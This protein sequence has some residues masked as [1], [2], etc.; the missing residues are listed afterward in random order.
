MTLV[1][2]FNSLR[3]LGGCAPDRRRRGCVARDGYGDRKRVGEV[4]GRFANRTISA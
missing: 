1:G 3:E 4:E 2:Y